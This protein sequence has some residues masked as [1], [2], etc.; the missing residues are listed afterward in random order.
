MTGESISDQSSAGTRESTGE[1]RQ[2][3]PAG[4]ARPPVVDIPDI[5]NDERFIHPHFF[6]K[7]LLLRIRGPVAQGKG[8]RI[9]GDHIGNH[10]SHYRNPDEDGDGG[11]DPLDY[12]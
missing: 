12:V 4:A 2:E 11:D 3:P 5:L 7:G 1:P 8:H 10:E 9:A 6:A